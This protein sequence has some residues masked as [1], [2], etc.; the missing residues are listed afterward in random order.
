MKR[1]N[2]PCEFSLIGCGRAGC[3]LAYAL[4]VAGLRVAALMDRNRKA[5][6]RAF[7]FLGAGKILSSVEEVPRFSD[8]VF[9]AV[10]DSEIRLVAEEI[11]KKNVSLEGKCFFHLSGALGPGVLTA[12]EKRG[13][14]VGSMH[15]LQTFPRPSKDRSL[16]EGI[17]F[18]IA[19]RRP[20]C[21]TAKTLIR[22]IGAEAVLIQGKE[23]SLYHAASVIACNY[24]V[25]LIDEALAILEHIGISRQKARKALGP[26]VKRAID[27]CFERGPSRALSGPVVRVDCET[28]EAHLRALR[29]YNP[30]L[31]REYCSFGLKAV[32]LA[33]SGGLIS[34]SDSDRLRGILQS[35]EDS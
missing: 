32:R 33:L 9:V 34:R 30:E 3:S 29:A 6:A 14:S 8:L 12:L 13:A 21:A 5:A 1:S 10:P 4:R 20:A 27:N 18:G 15:P 19:G 26:L 17:F 35:R 25:L 31:R 11:A 23:K 24:P 7:R 16:F 22:T 28:V 2:L